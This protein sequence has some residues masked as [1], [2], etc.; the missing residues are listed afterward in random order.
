METWSWPLGFQPREY[1]VSQVSSGWDCSPGFLRISQI[2]GFP[3]PSVQDPIALQSSGTTLQRCHGHRSS[4]RNKQ[5]SGADTLPVYQL[6]MQPSWD[7]EPHYWQDILTE[8]LWQI[9]AGTLKKVD[10]PQHKMTEQA[11]SLESQ[12]PGPCYLGLE[13]C[14]KNTWV[15]IPPV[16]PPTPSSRVP[17]KGEQ[18]QVPKQRRCSPVWPRSLLWEAIHFWSPYAGTLRTLGICGKDQMSCLDNQRSW[19]SHME[20]RTCRC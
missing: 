1:Q 3:T 7:S 18:N 6:H 2:W 11:P 8:Q 16:L 17:K 14:T 15:L 20:W 4:D 19:P 13:P 9:F 10:Q 5:P 12:E